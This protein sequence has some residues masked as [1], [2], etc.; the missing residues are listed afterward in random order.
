MITYFGIMNVIIGAIVDNM[1]QAARRASEELEEKQLQSR[2]ELVNRLSEAVRELDLD[3]D[4]KVTA[5]EV[6]D[7]ARPETVNVSKSTLDLLASLPHGSAE[8]LLRLLDIDGSGEV[9]YDEF[10]TGL[11]FIITGDQ[12]KQFYMM[13]SG[14]NSCKKLIRS[15]VAKQESQVAELQQQQQ[16]AQ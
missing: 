3:H 7:M 1:T 2:R 5:K 15:K 6:E 12:T 11:Y 14:I 16:E 10:I 13:Q 4:G 9:T 8:E